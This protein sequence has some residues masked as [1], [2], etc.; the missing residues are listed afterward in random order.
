MT[1]MNI[2]GDLPE[3]WNFHKGDIGRKEDFT[4]KII[5]LK[6]TEGGKLGQYEVS[7]LYDP[8]KTNEISAL[9]K[10][11]ENGRYSSIAAFKKNFEGK[12]VTV[13]SRVD[14]VRVKKPKT[15]DEV[16]KDFKED[17]YPSDKAIQ[18]KAGDSRPA[19]SDLKERDQA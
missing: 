17:K 14:D 5:K 16:G 11:I 19:E 15:Q 12:N 6:N 3:G 10:E 2:G 4:S 9:A 8:K 18:R 13:S 1:S 7:I